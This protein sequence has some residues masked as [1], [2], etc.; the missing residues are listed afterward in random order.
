MVT[1]EK[2]LILDKHIDFIVNYGKTH[3]KYVNPIEK[4]GLK[5]LVK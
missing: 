5:I 1:E 2:K 3:D 4:L